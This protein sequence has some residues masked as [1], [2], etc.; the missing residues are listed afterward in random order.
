MNCTQIEKF[1]P[2]Y[3]G[4][5][6]SETRRQLVAAH[7]VSCAACTAAVADFQHARIV[8]HGFASPVFSDEVYADIRQSVWRRIDSDSRPSP[9]AAVA[10][11]F[12]PRLVW[13]ATAAL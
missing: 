12:R 4:H 7:L 1:L 10:A 8:M 11:W 6:L 13:A 9:F 2:L 3:A 5:D